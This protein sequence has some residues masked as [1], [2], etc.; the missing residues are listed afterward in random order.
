VNKDL[1]AVRDRFSKFLNDPKHLNAQTREIASTFLKTHRDIIT[2]AGMNELATTGLV[3]MMGGLR[4]RRRMPSGVA[5]TPDLFSGFD[6]DPVVV[7]RVSESGGSAVEK[8]KSVA[9]LTWAEALD[10][11]HRH[12]RERET[13]TKRIR[14]WRRLL[15]RAKPYMTGNPDMTLGEAMA[16][17]AAEEEAN[18]SRRT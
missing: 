9:D 1:I 16:L 17:A 12:D 18:R 6:I 5:T 7:V 8:N 4:S 10:Y 3:H 14:E 2:P 11:V 15:K 13:N